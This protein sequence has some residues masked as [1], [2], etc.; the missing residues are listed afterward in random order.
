VHDTRTETWAG[1]WGMFYYF[2]KVDSRSSQPECLIS[3][4]PYQTYTADIRSAGSSLVIA[5]RCHDLSRMD[6]SQLRIFITINPQ[7][8]Q[9]PLYLV[10][11]SAIRYHKSSKYP[12]SHSA[13]ETYSP[14]SLL[15]F[16]YAPASPHSRSCYLLAL[17]EFPTSLL[18]CK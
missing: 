15:S 3:E 12:H 10:I 2:W 14:L 11:W 1:Y 17:P 7:S 18:T 4:S 6:A 5:F 16:S 8:A 13:S 9:A